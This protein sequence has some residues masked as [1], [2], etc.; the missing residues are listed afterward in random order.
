MN[1]AS[2]TIFIVLISAIFYIIFLVLGVGG[3]AKNRSA[4]GLDQNQ[5]NNN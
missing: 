2:I 1:F 3:I 4:Q 5:R